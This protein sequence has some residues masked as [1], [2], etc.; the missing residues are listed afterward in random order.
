M[1]GGRTPRTS[2]SKSAS[3]Y[4]FWWDDEEVCIVLYDLVEVDTSLLN[5][6]W[7]QPIRLIVANPWLITLLYSPLNLQLL[8]F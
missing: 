6:P 8:T 3:E 4:T 7:L 1:L 5:L 2:P